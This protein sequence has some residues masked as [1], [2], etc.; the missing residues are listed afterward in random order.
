MNHSSNN[1][2]VDAM[3]E[4]VASLRDDMP[5]PD[6][7]SRLQQEMRQHWQ[8][9]EDQPA[10]VGVWSQWLPSTTTRLVGACSA[11]VVVIVAASLLMHTLFN[12]PSL[13]A[14]AIA[15]VRAAKTVLATGGRY[16][17][18]VQTGTSEIW[19]DA[20]RGVYEQRTR[21]GATSFRL[22]NGVFEWTYRA[23]PNTIIKKLSRDTMGEI[24]DVLLP[25][26]EIDKNRSETHARPGRH[27]P[28]HVVPRL[29]GGA[30]PVHAADS[31]P[32]VAR[33]ARSTRPF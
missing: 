4:R 5:S 10:R 3:D 16:K 15:A 28:G 6:V 9:L 8:S 17:N 12:P 21:E 20:E 29:C 26:E 27:D 14:Q 31:I 2:H 30:A 33:R 24:D 22:D 13:Y 19:Y 18:G 1:N 7:E 25:L 11:A 32:F 23:G